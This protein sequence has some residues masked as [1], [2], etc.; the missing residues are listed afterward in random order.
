MKGEDDDNVIDDDNAMEEDNS[1]VEQ[2]ISDNIEF[3]EV[4]RHDGKYVLY[5]VSC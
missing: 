2:T 3:Y 4:E 5:L 1:G